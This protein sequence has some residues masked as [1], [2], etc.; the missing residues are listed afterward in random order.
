MTKEVKIKIGYQKTH[1]NK[2]QSF[3]VEKISLFKHNRSILVQNFKLLK[4]N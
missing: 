3:L 2:Q 4:Q 1:I